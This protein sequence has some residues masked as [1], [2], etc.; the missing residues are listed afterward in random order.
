MPI[1][2]T[3]TDV[4]P[5]RLLGGLGDH[6][7]RHVHGRAGAYRRHRD[8]RP[9]P[10]GRPVRRRRRR[11][12]TGH[13][14]GH[15]PGHVAPGEYP[16]VA[17][18]DA[19]SSPPTSSPPAPVTVEGLAN[20]SVTKSFPSGL[21]LGDHTR[22]DGDLPHPGR[23]RRP[24]RRQRRR[25]HRRPPTGFPPGTFTPTAWR[26]VSVTPPGP[27]PVCDLAPST[28]DLGDL[29][30]G[31]TVELELDVARR[32][33][34]ASIRTSAVTNTATSLRR[35]TIP[36]PPTTPARS[37]RRLS[38][39]PICR[40]A[41]SPPRRTAD[42]RSTRRDRVAASTVVPHRDRQLRSIGRHRRHVHRHAAAR[43][44]VRA[45]LRLRDRTSTYAVPRLHRHRRAGNRPDRLVPHLPPV[46]PPGL[47][48]HI[49]R[50]GGHRRPD[51]AGRH[52]A[53]EQ[54]HGQSD[55]EDG[56]P[57]NN[58]ST[59]LVPVR[60]EVNLSRREAGGR[61]G[62]QRDFVPD[63]ADRPRPGARTRSACPRPPRELRCQSSPTMARRR[64]PTCSS[65]TPSPSTPTTSPSATATS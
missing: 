41:R 64:P 47:R 59:A 46:R 55:V 30:P 2:V 42:R 44:D 54:H 14:R 8:V 18:A 51:D 16:N 26:V 43:R 53:G 5:R 56:N 37:P 62:R 1:P 65:S 31:T 49:L 45:H 63:S 32:R 17:T 57:G 12:R 36:T 40:S 27:T 9:G 58:T 48:R 61:D 4:L 15:R 52:G 28:C 11:D 21:R 34:L 35:P 20:V 13:D 29:P 6:R 39:R 38:R 23:Q 3:V 60:A 50:D 25:R 10:A 19:P 7:S 22:H 33:Q 24:V